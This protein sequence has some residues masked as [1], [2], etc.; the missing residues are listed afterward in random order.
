[1][2]RYFLLL[3]NLRIQNANAM[4]SPYTIGFP[5]MTSWLGAVHALQRQLNKRDYPD[6]RL[7]RL[8][9]ICHQLD[10]QRYRYKNKYEEYYLLKLSSNPLICKSANKYSKPDPF[11]EARCHVEVSL[12]IELEEDG[13]NQLF[14]DKKEKEF[15]IEVSKL[16]YGMKWASGDILSIQADNI[17]MWLLDDEDDEEGLNEI[18]RALWPGHILIEKQS[19]IR[20]AQQEE[21]VDA[22]QALL[23]YLKITEESNEKGDIVWKKRSPGWLVPIAVGF[24]GITAL[25]EEPVANQ[26]DKSTSHRFAESVVTLGEFIMPHRFNNIDEILW[27]YEIDLDRNLYL[28]KNEVC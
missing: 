21:N 23:D 7:S 2:S 6:V 27:H 15:Y 28:C 20:K 25:A 16:V 9:V 19:L 17:N 14:R 18:R 1:M 8:A 13:A 10:V 22:L 11:P 4:S 24:Q 3:P 12:L 5:A 26:R